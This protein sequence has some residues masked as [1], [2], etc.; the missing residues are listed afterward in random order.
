MNGIGRDFLKAKPLCGFL[1]VDLYKQIYG[2]LSIPFF[3]WVGIDIVHHVPDLFFCIALFRLIFRDYIPNQ[4]MVAFTVAFLVAVHGI[5]VKYPA[6]DLS[7][8]RVRFDFHRVG[9]LAPPVRHDYLKQHRKVWLPKPFSQIPEDLCHARRRIS[10]PQ[11]H[12]LK[13][14]AGQK[15]RQDHLPAFLDHHAVHLAHQGVRILGH[16]GLVILIRS[17]HV[18]FPVHPENRAAFLPFWPPQ[19]TAQVDIPGIQQACIDI[20]VD[21]AVRDWQFIPVAFANDWKG[22]SLFSAG[23]K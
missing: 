21:G 17:P 13:V 19:L 2:S 20:G 4:F 3:S 10:L 22:L 11:E 23:V 18:A 7:C 12:Q 8:F 5:A 9:K 16:I 1:A 14:T 15:N 6:L